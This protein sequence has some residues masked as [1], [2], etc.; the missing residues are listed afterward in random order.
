[1]EKKKVVKFVIEAIILTIICI[2][3]SYLLIKDSFFEVM[4]LIGNLRFWN[5]LI[6]VLIVFSLVVSSGY[7]LKIVANHFNKD[8]SIKDGTQTSLVG[9]LFSGITPFKVGYQFGVLYMY[10]KKKI[11]VKDGVVVSYVE[12]TSYQFVVTLLCILLSIYIGFNPVKI[13]ISNKIININLFIYLVSG[14]NVLFSSGLI[15]LIKFRKLHEYVI[16]ICLKLSKIFLRKRDIN[17]IEEKL[18]NSLNNIVSNSSMLFEN[19][20]QT[21]KIM[22][23][24]FIRAII[25]YSLPYLI[26]LFL[27]KGNF[28]FGDYI[29][30]LVYAMVIVFC[31]WIIPIPGGAG[32]SE[33]IFYVLYSLVISDE[34]MIKA[35]IL[36]WRFFTYY[37][38]LILGL[39][40]LLIVKNKDL[41]KEV[42]DEK[43]V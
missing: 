14:I 21:L 30:C 7:L 23:V 28:V 43:T 10:N 11:K 19:K 22:I 1:M 37:I 24:H 39:I 9:S 26:Y 16:K 6:L 3:V 31:L 20:K 40:V 5:L 36:V 41:I 25:T 34:V 8:F 29:V 27:S 12:G 17:E 13:V 42:K 32:A 33:M 2:V 18:R 35:A 38:N 4:K 15:L